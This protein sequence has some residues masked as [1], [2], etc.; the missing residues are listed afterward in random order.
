MLNQRR[1]DERGFVDHGW[2]KSH[3]S[4]SF[5]SYYDPQHM[6]VSALRVLNDDRV[7]AGAGFPTH[8]HRDMEIL[9]Y[10][11][12]GAL[13]H[14]DNMGNIHTMTAGE[15]QL[16]S[17]GTGVTHSEYNPL[18][19]TEARFLQVW[20][21]PDQQ[22]IAP[23]YQQE[24]F[25]PREGLQLI[26]APAG[27]EA[28]AFKIQQDAR[29]YRLQLKAGSSHTLS[30]QDKRP[31]YLH[32]ISGKFEVNGL[33]LEDGD[34]LTVRDEEI[35]VRATETAEALLFDLPGRMI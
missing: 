10:V 18:P 1:K 30:A 32:I 3:H 34:A 12:E 7:E 29:I 17:A 4:F 35:E 16:M 20:I 13:E 23:G 15:F 11:L 31:R 33:V 9:S 24:L 14:K 8:P 5:G 22:G 2:L 26:A 19:D 25:S 28:K 27:D 6:G 21:Q